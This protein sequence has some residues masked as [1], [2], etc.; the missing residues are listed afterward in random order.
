MSVFLNSSLSSLRRPKETNQDM[1]KATFRMPAVSPTCNHFCYKS[2]YN[3]CCITSNAITSIFIENEKPLKSPIT[4]KELFL[5]QNLCKTPTLETQSMFLL[6]QNLEQIQ[7]FYEFKNNMSSY[8][9]MLT[10]LTRKCSNYWEHSKELLW[11]Y[12][13]FSDL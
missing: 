9:D 7:T 10:L 2:V 12:L 1:W 6:H 13:P 3:V 11:N 5:L 8:W 4:R